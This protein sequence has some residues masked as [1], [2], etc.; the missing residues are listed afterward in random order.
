MK[1]LITPWNHQLKA[2]EKANQVRDLALFFEMGTGKTATT[3]NILRHR[4]AERK[5]LLRT[6]ILAPPVVLQN[7]KREFAMHSKIPSHHVVILDK[8]GSRRVKTFL[9]N[10]ADPQG[11]LVRPKVIITNY[12]AMQMDELYAAIKDWKPQL[13]VCDESHMLK[14]IKSKRSKRVATLTEDAEHRYILTGTPILNTGMDIF[15]QFLILDAGET[16]GKNFYVFRSNY[17]EDE[18]SGFAGKPNYFPKFSE[19]AET[20]G[21]LN[22]KIYTKAL[23]VKKE[24]CLDLPPLVREIREVPLSL[25]QA[26]LY[27]DMRDDYVAYIEELEKSTQPRAVV[28]QLAI[29]KALRLQQIVSGYAK[30]E[31]GSV[32]TI[33]KNPRLDQLE[34]LLA[35]LAPQ[36][37]VI[38]WSVFKENYRQIANVCTRLKLLYTELHGGVPSTQRDSNINRFCKDPSCRVIIANQ[39]AG[40]TGVNLIQASYSIYFSRNFSLGHDLQSE[41]RNHRGGS[42]MHARITRVDLVAPGTIDELLMEALIKKQNISEQVLGWRRKI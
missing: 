8:S 2:I 16:F 36:H 11:C 10:V 3:I 34:E 13:I 28:A 37:K 32:Y 24:E 1:Y 31:D 38:V 27:K 23:R 25:E 42:E 41:A 12:E 9:D 18:N 20:Y 19:R 4:Y 7:W 14:N 5:K 17:F 26:K 39:A 15:Q 21:E 35:E 22:K 29:T 30:T 40:G 6:L 33:K